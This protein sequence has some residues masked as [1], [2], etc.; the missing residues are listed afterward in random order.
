MAESARKWSQDAKGELRIHVKS[1]KKFAYLIYDSK[2]Y[3]IEVVQILTLG[4]AFHSHVLNVQ[5]LKWHE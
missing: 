1:R 3:T 4:P 5:K 2:F